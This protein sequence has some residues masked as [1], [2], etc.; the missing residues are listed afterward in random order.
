MIEATAP[1][2]LFVAGEYAVVEPGGRAVL[3]AV[4]RYVT[5]TV[6]ATGS[7]APGDARGRILSSRYRDGER[8]WRRTGGHVLT[9]DDL[10]ADHVVAALTVMEDLREAHGRPAAS[11]D[12]LV[13]SALDAG[14]RKL[15]LGSSAA[16]TVAVVRALA[17]L[18]DLGLD[19]RQTFRA[20]M[21]AALEV[22][23]TSGGDIAA[24][25]YGGWVDYRS[26]DRDAARDLRRTQGIRSAVADR[27]PGL[28]I[29]ALPSPAHVDVHVGWTGAPASTPHLVRQLQER[30][31]DA[32]ATLEEF[33]RRS[34]ACVGDLVQALRED[35]PRSVLTGIR[36]ARELLRRLARTAGVAI[37]TP[38]LARLAASAEAAGAAGKSSGAGG[39]DCGIVFAP[40]GTDLSAM[41]RAWNVAGIT[42]MDLSTAP[43]THV[44]ELR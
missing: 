37:E 41:W 17:G 22:A 3:I 31:R 13:D 34:D 7:A 27:W 11:Y 32:A 29:A 1:G 23:G 12:L 28:H 5:V 2:K 43:S 8:R 26:P 24:S 19:R 33:R 18:Y 14:G 36:T 16:V 30:T 4:D 10:G 35:A 42:R 39:G 20:A 38:M 25:T 15:G 6:R 40:T 9:E 44:R 21:L